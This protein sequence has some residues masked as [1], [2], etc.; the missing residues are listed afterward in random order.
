[1]KN[2][3][4]SNIIIAGAALAA[5]CGCSGFLSDQVPQGAL[6]D[7]Q[8]NAP[9]FIDGMVASAYAVFTTAE[10]V[11]TSFSLWNFDIRSDDAYKGGASP[12][13]EEILQQLEIGKG[14]GTDAWYINNIWKR[15]YEVI[16]RVNEAIV[17]VERMDESDP[18][19][20]ERLAELRFLRAYAHFQL[21][22]L[23]KQIPFVLR[24][25]YAPSDYYEISNTEYTN[26]EG[27]GKIAN[28][29]E[30][31]LMELPETQAEKG[32]PTK[33]AAA[34]FLA[35]I[36]LYKA[37]R[38]DTFLSNE[39]TEINQEDLQK[40][41]QY[42]DMIINSGKYRLEDDLHNNFRPEEQYKNGPESI[43]AIQ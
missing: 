34:A 31:A 13:D 3:I 38:Q 33:A 37:Y 43:W 19:K 1:M 20:N 26:D 21:K 14:F 29:V 30:E 9:A 12:S 11:S 6:T 23:F 2:H 17:A 39:V 7:E 40:V 28:E 15:F 25:D 22:R 5:V 42:T 8:M 24:T 32:R 16:S 27:W 10:D 18:L 41:I 36:Y 4:L 35:K